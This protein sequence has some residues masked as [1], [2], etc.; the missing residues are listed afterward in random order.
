VTKAD[1]IDYLNKSVNYFKSNETLVDEEFAKIVFEDE[2]MAQ[3]F[4]EHREAYTQKHELPLEDSFQISAASVKKQERVLKSVLK[5]DKNF[6][7]Y[8]HGNREMIERGFDEEKGK[9]FYK[10]YFEEEQ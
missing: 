7:I 3:A 6:H 10:V 5:L 4:H 1:K 2:G 8:I 9:S